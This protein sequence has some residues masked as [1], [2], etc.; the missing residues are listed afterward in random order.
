MRTTYLQFLFTAGTIRLPSRGSGGSSSGGDTPRDDKTKRRDTCNKRPILYQR[1][2]KNG[3]VE[4]TYSITHETFRDKTIKHIVL[5][6][7]KEVDIPIDKK[8]LLEMIGAVHTWQCEMADDS[9]I[10]ILDSLVELG[11]KINAVLIH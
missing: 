1:G 4:I 8:P 10:L 3:Y 11:D 2:T 9:P 5:S 6:S 7:W